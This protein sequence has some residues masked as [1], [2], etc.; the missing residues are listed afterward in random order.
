MSFVKD[1][2]TSQK[3]SLNIQ[4]SVFRVKTSSEQLPYIIYFE[5][6]RANDELP[7]TTE[8]KS[9]GSMDKPGSNS[10]TRQ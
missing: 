7:V 8:Q 10:F 9:T 3:K 4:D 6:F 5:H 1:N 2:L